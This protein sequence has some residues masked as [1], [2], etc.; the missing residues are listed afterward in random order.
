[1]SR[2]CPGQCV[3]V[4]ASRSA[5][6]VQVEGERARAATRQ[7]SFVRGAVVDGAVRAH[8]EGQDAAGHQADTDLVGAPRRHVH[9]AAARA[10]RFVAA[11]PHRQDR[12]RRALGVDGHG[13][14]PDLERR[15]VPAAEVPVGP[16]LEVDGALVRD[17]EHEV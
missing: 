3:P 5:R 17:V 11:T 9:R 13:D 7:H 14:P 1:M 16:G 4:S 8:A 15:R 6:T 2:R 12:R 10:H